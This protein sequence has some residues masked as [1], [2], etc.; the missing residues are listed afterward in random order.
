MDADRLA[1]AYVASV[2]LSHRRETGQFFTPLA[3]A[4]LMGRWV[5]SG[6][7]GPVFDPA[8]GL[9][10]LHA[11]A[12]EVSPTVEFRGMELDRVILDYYRA[13]AGRAAS[14]PS[15]ERGDYLRHWNGVHGRIVCNP[16][17]MRFQNFPDRNAVLSAF[18]EKLGVRLSG[19]MNSASAFLLKSLSEL[20]PGGRLAY[21]MPL[22][23]L[24]T[25][26]G[27]EVKRRL[28]EN[29]DLKVLVRVAAE[30]EMF[31]DATTTVGLILVARDGA[32]EPVRFH[33]AA[34]LAELDGLLA[35]TPARAV[36]LA[37]LDPAAKWLQ[38][39]DEPERISA[40]ADLVPLAHYGSFSRGIATGANEYFMLAREEA[41]EL[42]LERRHLRRCIGRSAQIDTPILTK[43]SF[44]ALEKAGAKVLLFHAGDARDDA[45]RDYIR[46]G[47]SLGY[48]L[49][50]LTRTRSPWYKLED[51]ASAPLLFGVFSRG[52]FKVIR[53]TSG[54]VTL[55]CYHGF[56]PNLFG[57]DHV[58]GLFLYL[59]S[60][61][62]RK[63][64]AA[65]MRQYGDGLGKFEPNDL[66]RARVPGPEWM[67]RLDP[68]LARDAMQRMEKSGEL[69]ERVERF[70]ATLVSA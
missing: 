33:R 19:Y 13:R 42:G 68:E 70:F 48:H 31:P 10:A 9:G 7:G 26:Y 5:L 29:G 43:E 41:R 3:A 54:A 17:Y 23:F 66:N 35:T 62:A 49:R 18:K 12:A 16:P 14:R 55:T 25:G 30:R 21:L 28:I 32:R 6:G 2:P 65:D 11:G 22:E 40:D 46:R 69:P 20:A 15:V 67:S 58:D 57:R 51:R 4:A 61:A 24:N 1:A 37:E 27:T 36:P 8:F 56:L 39:F 47:E 34:S 50:Y 38:Y 59:H 44:K 53:N 52:R 60:R 63:I 45:A 64:L